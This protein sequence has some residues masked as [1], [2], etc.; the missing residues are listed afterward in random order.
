[1]FFN[2][3][4]F[5]EMIFDGDYYDN[6]EELEE[7]KKEIKEVENEIK[8]IKTDL[9]KRAE[10]IVEALKMQ[11]NGFETLSEY[12]MWVKRTLALPTSI[13][14][15]IKEN[16][17]GIIEYND[18]L[19]E[20]EIIGSRIDIEAKILYEMQ[21]WEEEKDFDVLDDHAEDEIEDYYDE[22]MYYKEHIAIYSTEMD[23]IREL[24]T[25]SERRI[26]WIKTALKK[27]CLRDNPVIV[28]TFIKA[29]LCIPT[30]LYDDDDCFSMGI[31]ELDEWRDIPIIN[32]KKLKEKAKKLYESG[33]CSL[34]IYG[35]DDWN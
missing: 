25:R 4:I 32:V 18:E 11:K 33:K 23:V 27:I 35:E 31:I 16:N 30:P 14:Y 22:Y 7:L 1:M 20:P 21:L 29:I 9:V 12:E 5:D 8:E 17:L 26:G 24:Y 15:P 10:E 13:L 6:Y 2:E 28:Q 19:K 34:S 3:M